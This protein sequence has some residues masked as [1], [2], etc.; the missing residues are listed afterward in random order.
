MDQ[1]TPF[2]KA[3]LKQLGDLS[4]AC[5]TSLQQSKN[6]SHALS[7]LSVSI[8]Q[9]V[10]EIEQRQRALSAHLSDLGNALT[11]QSK[12]IEFYSSSVDRLIRAQRR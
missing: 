3:L 7:D 2:E 9:R 12:Q 4:R 5:E 10:D 11:E 1:M 8:G 6:V